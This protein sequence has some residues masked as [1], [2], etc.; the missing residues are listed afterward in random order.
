MTPAEVFSAHIASDSSP[1]CS[2]E[3][4][5]VR[6]G[7]FATHEAYG[8]HL[9][10]AL[11]AAGY[12]VIDVPSVAYKGELDTDAGAFLQVAQ[13]LD[14]NLP[15]G[16]SNVCAAVSRLLRNVAAALTDDPRTTRKLR[17]S[18]RSRAAAKTGHTS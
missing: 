6:C 12:V 5:C 11:I 2:D 7:E 17:R 18:G 16:G 13:N 9:H 3:I 1:T 8:A 14:R 15:A 10:D 4:E